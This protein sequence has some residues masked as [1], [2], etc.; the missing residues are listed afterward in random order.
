MPPVGRAME[1]ETPKLLIRSFSPDD[2]KCIQNL[3][4]N[5]M[6]PKKDP[7]DHDLPVD[8]DGCMQ[9]ARWFAEHE[10]QFLAVCLQ[11]NGQLI[12]FLAFNAVDARGQLDVGHV[13]HTDF[14]DDDHDREALEYGFDIAFRDEAIRAIET[15]NATGWA[16]QCAPLWSLGLRPIGNDQGNL[17]ITRNDWE[18]RRRGSDLD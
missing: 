2:W 10:D 11:C 14:Q 4:V 1:L 3:T 15:R 6:S 13:I 12:G 7:Q 8:D 18:S 16:E 9:M 5:K 17:A